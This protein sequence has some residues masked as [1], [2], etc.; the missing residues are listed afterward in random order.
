MECE[1]AAGLVL[2]EDRG[3][4]ATYHCNDCGTD[5]L[6]HTSPAMDKGRMIPNGL[7][8]LKSVPKKKGRA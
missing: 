3:R 1:H 7:M 6:A 8:V 5:F 2:V 4:T